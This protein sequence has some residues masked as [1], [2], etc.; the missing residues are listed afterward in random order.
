MAM[1]RE[2]EPLSQD[3]RLMVAAISS[4]PPPRTTI[5]N[6]PAPTSML[7]MEPEQRSSDLLDVDTPTSTSIAM[8]VETTHHGT[9]RSGDTIEVW[10]TTSGDHLSK[11]DITPQKVTATTN[12]SEVNEEVGRIKKFNP[13]SLV[14][15]RKLF[16]VKPLLSK[17]RELVVARV[18]KHTCRL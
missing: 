4:Q 6:S 17:E 2:E 5:S 8:E 3:L 14:A 7:V 12:T 11:P 13:S 18:V 1:M 9:E 10:T 15:Y 16:G